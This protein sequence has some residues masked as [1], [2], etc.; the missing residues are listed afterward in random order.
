[1]F[2]LGHTEARNL[3]LKKSDNIIGAPS[4]EA[5]AAGPE[6]L[7]EERVYEQAMRRPDS[8]ALDFRVASESFAEVRALPRRF[9]NPLGEERS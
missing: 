7:G 5:R 3:A 4:R 2:G 8:E 1:M 6:W 9:P